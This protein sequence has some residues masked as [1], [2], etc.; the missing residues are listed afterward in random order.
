MERAP[1]T[2]RRRIRLGSIKLDSIMATHVAQ[3]L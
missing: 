1:S 3:A 2:L